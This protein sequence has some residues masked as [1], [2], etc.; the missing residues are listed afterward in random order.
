MSSYGL[1]GIICVILAVILFLKLQIPVD[2]GNSNEF[3][4]WGWLLFLAVFFG[5]QCCFLGYCYLLFLIFK[6]KYYPREKEVL[7]YGWASS[8]L[9]VVLSFIVSW[10]LSY[11]AAV[12]CYLVV[13]PA[14][15]FRIYKEFK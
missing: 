3:R 10:T 2:K 9:N 13:F 4:Q 11:V 1:V 15:C 8:Y 12:I 6:P 14:L 5:I 7:Y